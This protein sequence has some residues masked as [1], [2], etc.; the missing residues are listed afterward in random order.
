MPT[1]AKNRADGWPMSILRV[2][3]GS[4]FPLV[5][6]ILLIWP[7]T[8]WAI[9]LCTTQTWNGILACPGTALPGFVMPPVARSLAGERVMASGRPAIPTIYH[10]SSTLAKAR[11]PTC[12]MP[13]KLNSPLGTNKR[14][15]HLTGVLASST[16]STSNPAAPLTLLPARNFCRECPSP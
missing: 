14:Y 2:Q 6:A 9:S 7:S 5:T 13:K 3:N 4:W 15:S 8:M 11:Q 12:F 1:T 10:P 16:P